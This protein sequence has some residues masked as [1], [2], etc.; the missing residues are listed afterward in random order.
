MNDLLG[1]L[2]T[3]SLLGLLHL[4]YYGKLM[5]LADARSCLGYV[6]VDVHGFLRSDIYR[7]GN[8]LGMHLKCFLSQRL[9][10]CEVY[11]G[12]HL[13]KLAGRLKDS[14]RINA[15]PRI[16]QYADILGKRSQLRVN[17]V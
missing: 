10:E 5:S 7:C 3:L 13:A 11:Q 12:C 8:T 1:T 15:Q 9:D 14:D 16:L 17:L 4:I 6:N 2:W